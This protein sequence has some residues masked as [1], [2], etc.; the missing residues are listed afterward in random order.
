MTMDQSLINKDVLEALSDAIGAE[1]MNK[2]LIL[3]LKDCKI[4][5]NKIIDAY[6]KSQFSEVELEAH[7]LGTSAATYGALLLE[8]ICRE[9]ELAKPEKS[10]IFQNRIDRLN[11]LSKQSLDAIEDHFKT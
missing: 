5:T 4:R 2:F 11:V 9:I 1:S 10:E 6:E 3:F 8:K 7:T